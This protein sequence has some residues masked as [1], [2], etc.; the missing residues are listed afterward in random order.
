MRTKIMTLPVLTLTA[1]ALTI[2]MADGATARDSMHRPIQSHNER[3]GFNSEARSEAP[4]SRTGI[5]EMFTNSINRI[6]SGCA[7]QH[8]DNSESSN[9][10]HLTQ[11]EGCM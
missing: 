8:S 2:G 9:G 10:S 11:G 7:S 5:D 4:E 6:D 3:F 1:L